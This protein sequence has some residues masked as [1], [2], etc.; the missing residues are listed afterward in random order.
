MIIFTIFKI[1]KIYDS[2]VYLKQFFKTF[3]FYL[4]LDFST[5]QK[6]CYDWK[7]GKMN[8]G[9]K[10]RGIYLRYIMCK[11]QAV[12]KCGQCTTCRSQQSTRTKLRD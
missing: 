12:C 11:C 1:S 8:W 3:F 2:I 5:P 7:I 9:Q 4:L 10:V 6:K